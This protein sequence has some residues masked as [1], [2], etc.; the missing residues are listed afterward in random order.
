MPPVALA[1]P[2][3]LGAPPVPAAPPLDEL[4]PPALLGAPPAPAVPPEPLDAPD[5]APVPPLPAVPVAPS[6]AS[7]QP[8]STTNRLMTLRQ[9]KGFMTTQD[10]GAHPRR[11]K[12]RHSAEA[13][14]TPRAGPS[15]LGTQIRLS[16]S[17]PPDSDRR[18]G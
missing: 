13:V 16:T 14:R 9:S 10:T 2:P 11:V 17:T 7:E 1:P 3:P 4:V 15:D 18:F 8:P 12:N 6:G 5:E